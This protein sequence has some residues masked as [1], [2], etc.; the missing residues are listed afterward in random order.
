MININQ[1]M[2]SLQSAIQRNRQRN[3]YREMLR[4]LHLRYFDYKDQGKLDKYQRIVDRCRLIVIRNRGRG[5]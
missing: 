3:K 1:P 5:T 4:R 2:V